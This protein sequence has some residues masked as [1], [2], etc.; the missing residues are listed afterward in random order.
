MTSLVV[1]RHPGT[2]TL[3]GSFGGGLT[4]IETEYQLTRIL[5]SSNCSSQNRFH[6][7]KYF[8]SFELSA[9]N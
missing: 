9:L 8:N 7:I 5:S 6:R 2:D 1:L 4:L 3:G